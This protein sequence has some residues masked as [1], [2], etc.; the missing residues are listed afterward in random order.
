MKKIILFALYLS[1]FSLSLFA[2]DIDLNPIVV[3]SNRQEQR[4]SDVMTSVSVITRQDI[5]RLQPHDIGSIL[6]GQPGIEI[7]RAGGLGMQ[8]SIFM[9]GTNSSQVLVLVDGMKVT[10]EF[11]NAYIS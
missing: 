4:L 1:I 5:E 10:D 8:T 6:Q 2:E 3:I 11:S 7:V 9:R